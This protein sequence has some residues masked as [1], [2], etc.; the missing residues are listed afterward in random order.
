MTHRVTKR[1]LLGGLIVVIV[2]ISALDAW[3][4]NK[5]SFVRGVNLAGAEFGHLPGRVNFDYFWPTENEISAYSNRGVRIIRL[6]FMWERLQPKLTADFDQEE[7]ALLDAA[8]A[9]ITEKGIICLIDPHNYAQYVKNGKHFPI[10]SPQVPITA[11]VDFWSRI[12]L[13]FKDNP[14]VWFGL[15]NEPHDIRADR[16]RDIA[17]LAI[18]AIRN[19]GATN[20]VLVPGTAFSTARTWISSGNAKAMLSFNDP[21]NNFAFE[22][23]Q[24]LDANSS[25]TS[26][27]CAKGSGSNRLLEFEHWLK[28]LPHPTKGFLGEFAGGDSAI[29]GQKDCAPELTSLVEEVE[30]HRDLWLGWAVWGGGSQWAPDYH[31]RLE[32]PSLSADETNLMRFYRRYWSM[33]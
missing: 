6:P 10:G 2:F 33:K 25:G 24:Y 3:S 22:V 32:S 8:V 27:V 17:E 12:S 29:L 21:A 1:T 23:H 9:S 28:S 7:S 26:G 19:A 11:F 5:D 18:G 14:R 15:M 30:Q 16:W 20:K 31:F 4:Q 13:K